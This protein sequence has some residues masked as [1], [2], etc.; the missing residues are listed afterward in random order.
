MR[1]NSTFALRATGFVLTTIV[2]LALLPCTLWAQQAAVDGGV[3]W[4][5]ANQDASGLWGVDKETPYRDAAVVVAVLSTLDA[6]SVVVNNGLDAVESMSTNSTD[7]LARKI[8]ARASCG[9]DVSGYYVGRLVSMQNTDGGWGYQEGYGSNNLETALAL[10]ALKGSLYT[11]MTVLGIGAGYLQTSQNPDSGWSFVSGDSSSVFFTAHAVLALDA[12]AGDFSVGALIEGGANWLKTQALGDGGFGTGG[13]SN[14]YETGLAMAAIVKGDP[15]AT[16]IL[17]A[18]TYLESTQLPNGSWNDDAYS[19]ALAIYGLNHVG[20]DLLIESTDISLSNPMPSDSEIVTIDVTVRNSGVVSAD[21]ILVQVFDVL[22]DLGGTQIG[23]DVTIG[24]LAPLGDS[25][26]QVDWDTY[27]LAGDHRVYVF[28]D[29]LNQIREPDKLNNV[30]W[31]SVHV[32]LPPDLFIDIDGIAFNPPEPEVSEPTIIQITVK[33][34]GELTAVNIPLQVWDGDPDAGGTP[35]MGTPYNIVSIPPGSQFTL[36]LTMGTYFGTE[37]PFEIHACVDMDNAI[38]EISE[39]NNC[40]FDTLWVGTLS[41]PQTLYQGLN[42]LGLPLQPTTAVTSYGM[43]PQIPNCNEVDGWNRTGQMWMSAVDIGGGLIIGDDWPIVLRDGFFSRVTAAGTAPFTGMRVSEFGCTSLEQGLNIV[44]IPN[45]ATCYTA[46]TL[47]DDISTGVEAHTW[48]GNLQLWAAAA[49]I[50]EGVFVGEDFPVTPG[51]GYF[52]K[53]GAASEWCTRTCDTITVPDLPDLLVTPSDI[54]IN[55]NP[56]VS[57]EIV[58]IRMNV[59]NIGSD[60]AFTPRIDM[61]INDPD[62]PGAQ[63]LFDYYI[64]DTLAPGEATG[65]WGMNFIFAGSGTAPIFGLA[66]YLGEIAEIDETNNRASQNLTILPAAAAP[67]NSPGSFAVNL[68]DSDETITALDQG[69]YRWWISPIP[70]WDQSAATEIASTPDASES[71]PAFAAGSANRIENLTVGNFSSSSVTITWFT[72]EPSDGCVHFGTSPTLGMSS[73]DSE[74]AG[75]LHTIVLDHLSAETEYY[76]EVSSGGVTEN[77]AGSLYSFTTAVPGAGKP[78][79]LYGNVITSGVDLPAED[80]VTSGALTS[81]N[82]N[83][84]LVLSATEA[85]G[86]WVLNLGNLKSATSGEVVNHQTGDTIILKFYGS[87][88]RMVENSV[89]VTGSSPQDCGIFEIE[90]EAMCGDIDGSRELSIG[91]IVTLVDYM[92]NVGGESLSVPNAA[93]DVDCSGGID[94]SDLIYMVEYFF[95]S[96]PTPCRDCL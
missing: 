38:R 84:H 74:S 69:K 90:P 92:F 49:K 6:D 68:V 70:G 76:F 5:E 88:G 95:S 77:N 1:G 86:I 67:G 41:R 60:S 14:P 87:D 64:P 30:S 9:H 75:R 81:G 17:D 42:L 89:V 58:E 16:E 85:D 11:N 35:L 80:V 12:V 27:F 51:D 43:I 2:Y 3:A 53:V 28:V 63:K 25:T 66:D 91:D 37:G 10:K 39:I 71:G 82:D 78:Y 73:C 18:T 22:P 34:V 79:V 23:A 62:L 61:Y 54:Y 32:Y 65:Y 45:E 40:N 44:S 50:A 24:S 46:Y 31:K 15:T 55:P 33:N 29:P 83:T 21:N 8:V 96:G 57:G 48:D 4:L 93:G 94:I 20:P 26:I 47:I 72:D 36:E 52:V 7:F 56:V 59:T 19:T 13:A